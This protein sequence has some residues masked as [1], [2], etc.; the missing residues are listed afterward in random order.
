MTMNSATQSQADNPD[1]REVNRDEIAQRAYELWAAAGQP[2]GRDVEYWLQAETELRSRRQGP[3]AKA[4][5]S[6]DGEKGK[7]PGAS[8][9][10]SLV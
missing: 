7:S 4:S 2:I 5:F 8:A 3:S 10:S 1:R 9:P 6:S